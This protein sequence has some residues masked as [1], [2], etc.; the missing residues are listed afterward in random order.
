MSKLK[1]HKFVSFFA[2]FAVIGLILGGVTLYVSAQKVE[3]LPQWAQDAL[4][5]ETLNI[6][7][8]LLSSEDDLLNMAFPNNKSG[9]G[10]DFSFFVVMSEEYE[11]GTD[12][13][14]LVP[15]VSFQPL[16]DT[17]YQEIRKKGMDK[18]VRARMKKYVACVA[19]AE[20]HK[21]ASR[22]YDMAVVHVPCSQLTDM[23]VKTLGAID[24]GIS[25]DTFYSQH[26][27]TTINFTDT[28]YENVEDPLTYFAAR[29]YSMANQYDDMGD[30]SQSAAKIAIRCYL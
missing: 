6:D 23:F 26:A 5:E 27:G 8:E 30:V 18:A 12:Q 13:Q 4:K 2:L 9:C 15:Y 10:R 14:E 1:L 11:K 20:E 25:Y 22:E 21:N 17:V 19:E 29:L 7:P 3:D 24:R 16:V 28:A